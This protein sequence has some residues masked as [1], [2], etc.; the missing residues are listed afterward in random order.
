MAPTAEIPRRFHVL[1]KGREVAPISA[2]SI[3]DVN[4]D[5]TL[6]RFKLNG[7]VIAEVPDGVE[8][9]WLEET[10][11]RGDTYGV[12]MPSGAT[13]AVV[14]DDTCERIC[15]GGQRRRFFKRGIHTVGVVFDSTSVAWRILENDPKE[16]SIGGS[17][18]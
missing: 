2:D 11:A 7:R 4:Q 10:D 14:A 17:L 16:W 3:C 1:M 12:E 18:A 8:A 15:Q 9:W 6:L 5:G 13:F